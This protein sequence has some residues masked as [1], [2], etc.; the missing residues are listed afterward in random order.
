MSPAPAHNGALPASL[1]ARLRQG[2]SKLPRS[3]FA[4]SWIVA[5]GAEDRRRCYRLRLGWNGAYRLQP[6]ILP[7]GKP[8]ILIIGHTVPY[9][10]KLQQL[11]ATSPARLALLRTAPDEFPVPPAEMRFGMGLRG[12]DSYLYAL[13]RQHI[14]DLQ[15]QG[16]SPAA[17]LIAG[18]VETAEGCLAAVDEYFRYGAALDSL[19]T[20]RLF[21]PRAWRNLQ[22]GAGLALLLLVSGALL[23][24]PGMFSDMLEWR[25]KSLREQGGALPKINQITE[26]M[27]LAQAEAA[28]LYAGKDAALAPSLGKLFNALPTGYSLRSIEYKNG[29]LKV[30]GR[31]GND[32]TWLIAQGF[33]EESIT[34]TDLGSYQKFT[35]ERPL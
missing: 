10:R 16:L 25:A 2:W 11:P 18:D 17:V 7:A 23:A 3:P 35:A 6:A 33:A 13:P 20:R 21:S 1:K 32:K 27:V 22:L 28:R 30:S 12:A 4:P 9:R 14:A 29:I 19:K 31:G 5:A 8:C 15:E 26:K 24:K 34:I